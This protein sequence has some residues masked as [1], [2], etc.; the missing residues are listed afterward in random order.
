[1]NT[2]KSQLS[3][4]LKGETNKTTTVYDKTIDEFAEWI[5]E[6]WPNIKT[7]QQKNITNPIRYLYVRGKLSMESLTTVL[8]FKI[9][10]NELTVLNGPDKIEGDNG[11]TYSDIESFKKSLLD[12][13]SNNTF[14][15]QMRI[16]NSLAQKVTVYEAY[17]H[18][19]DFYEIVSADL[20]IELESSEQEKIANT[21]LGTTVKVICRSVTNELY[22]IKPFNKNCADQ[23]KLFESSGFL[24]SVENIEEIDADKH[25][26]SIAVL[27][28]T[29]SDKSTNKNIRDF[30]R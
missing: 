29:D 25:I 18:T 27:M 3:S 24:G 7:A 20:K 23:Y 10:D 4:A 13:A 22:G 11:T 26:L 1:M 17:I 5:E 14:E 19:R 12:I 21:Q 28:L 16:I 9:S 30:F 2:F 6:T 15:T 8:V